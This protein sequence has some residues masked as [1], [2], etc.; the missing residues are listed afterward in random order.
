MQEVIRHAGYS[1]RPILQCWIASPDFPVSRKADQMSYQMPANQPLFT[2]N[3]RCALISR[4][5]L[6]EAQLKEWSRQS[7]VLFGGQ[8][9]SQLASQ[10]DISISSQALHAHADR[11]SHRSCHRSV[12]RAVSE[13]SQAAES[14]SGI[15]L[16]F[17]L[18]CCGCAAVRVS[19][20]VNDDIYS[21]SST[22]RYFTAQLT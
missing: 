22:A 12:S 9:C 2:D 18:V 15:V 14:A 17:L 13:R 1:E 8:P 19:D 6:Q 16:S 5:R 11:V 10:A 21:G 4:I 7:D 3:D 20:F